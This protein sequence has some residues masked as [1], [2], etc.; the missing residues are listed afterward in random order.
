MT[1]DEM[2]PA[3]CEH[4]FDEAINNLHIVQE[5]LG[6]ETA[7]GYYQVSIILNGIKKDIKE[8]QRDLMQQ[9]KRNR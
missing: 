8:A 6:R 3:D 2:T 1:I 9:V 5:I 4:L 7:Y